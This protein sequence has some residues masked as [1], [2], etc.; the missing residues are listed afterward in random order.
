MNID[1]VLMKVG[2]NINKKI[3]DTVIGKMTVPPI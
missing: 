2:V 3:D 1:N